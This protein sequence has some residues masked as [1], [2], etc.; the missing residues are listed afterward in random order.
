MMKKKLLG[1][2]RRALLW[3]VCMTFL[4]GVC[5]S[6][7]AE[8]R[9][10]RAIEQLRDS[11]GKSY[12]LNHCEM[13]VFVFLS[14][15]SPEAYTCMPTVESMSIKSQQVAAGFFGVVCGTSYSISQVEGFRQECHA[16]FPVLIDKDKALDTIFGAKEVGTAIIVQGKKR[17]YSGPIDHRFDSLFKHSQKIT[18]EEELNILT[19]RKSPKL[20]PIEP[21]QAKV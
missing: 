17:I 14:P 3:S 13:I 12:S 4:C 18:L 15:G 7:Q 19:K 9:E 11:Q 2:L 21:G 6:V 20:R 1:E 16:N 8:T 10:Y 5:G